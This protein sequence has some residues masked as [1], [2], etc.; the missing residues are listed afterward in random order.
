MKEHNKITVGFVIQNYITLPNG[1][2]ICQNQDF[3]A[4]D[5]VDY[6]DNEGNPV[7]ID[8]TKEVYCPFEMKA[9]KQI[10][11]P[12]IEAKFT[13]S[14]CGCNRL[15]AVLDGSHTT[16]IEAIY[17]GGG[18]EYG[19]THSNG[20]LDRFQCVKCGETIIGDDGMAIRDDDELVEWVEATEK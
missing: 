2:M 9:P 14:S 5:Q 11:D 15:E 17:K 10:P 6:E 4:G 7:E 20:D 1:S 12:D 16:S 13:C 3:V 8:T 18:I 19:D